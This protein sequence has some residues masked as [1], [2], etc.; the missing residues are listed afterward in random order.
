M[1]ITLRRKI[2]LAAAVAAISSS[3]ALPASGQP[4]AA[5]DPVDLNQ[6]LKE[7]QDNPARL[8]AMYKV[9]RSVASFCANCHGDGGN[10]VKT[11]VPNLAGQHPS[12]LLQQLREFSTSERKS[13]EFKQRLVN[14]MSA[15]EKIGMVVF[16]AAQEV[17][18]K[19][20]SD[21][22]MLKRGAQLYA[23]KCVDCHERDGRGTSE[24][25]RVAGQQTVYLSQALKGYRDGTGRRLDKDMVKEVKPL[26]DADIAALVSYVSS[27]K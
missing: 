17:T 23:Q 18:H 26:T 8:Q 7:V 16:Y 19:P 12:Y 3:L 14:V 24:Y 10:S 1:N 9:G 20:P 6:R 25:S 4:G 27:M 5:S 22:A 13:S 21:P 15:D 11:D 2:G